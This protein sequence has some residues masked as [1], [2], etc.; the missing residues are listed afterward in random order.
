M[1]TS[2]AVDTL[3]TVGVKG[4]PRWESVLDWAAEA[5]WSRQAS[6]R[7]VHVLPTS[8]AMGA[9]RPGRLA[10]GDLLATA[11]RR[12]GKL[13]PAGRIETRLAAGPVPAALVEAAWDDA[14]TVVGSRVTAGLHDD[15]VVSTSMQV[16]AYAAAPVVVVRGPR[17][18]APVDPRVVV[19][20]EP[21]A[22]G[23]EALDLAFA[24]AGLRGA[25][26]VAVHV[27]DEHRIGPTEA[28]L[29]ERRLR[30]PDVDCPPALVDGTGLTGLETLLAASRSAELIV[31]GL[32]RGPGPRA[33]RTAQVC[34]TLLARASCP[35]GVAQAPVRVPAVSVPYG[36]G[37]R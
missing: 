28:L 25:E 7:I 2:T 8:E 1:T 20:V 12:A 6:L 14:L 9:G 26:L 23:D 29:A 15:P 27:G 22:A 34:R 32:H 37:S 13:L 33:L 4:S 36:D 19:A 11:A 30:Y 16:A 10:A 21:D 3:I 35:V 5:A 31:A 18:S 24:E 17:R